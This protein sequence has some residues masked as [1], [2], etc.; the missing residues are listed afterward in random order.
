[1]CTR[2]TIPAVRY[3]LDSG[4]MGRA[5]GTITIITRK[6]GPDKSW[7]QNSSH[8]AHVAQCLPTT[9]SLY[10]RALLLC[11][12]RTVFGGRRQGWNQPTKKAGSRQHSSFP[13]LRSSFWLETEISSRRD[14]DYVRAQTMPHVPGVGLL[15]I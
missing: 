13:H 9:A 11:L 14:F 1:M 12:T 7:L 4:L 5:I 2:P 8:V 15:P 3:A 10:T 6:I